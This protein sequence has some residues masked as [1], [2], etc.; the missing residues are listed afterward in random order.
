MEISLYFSYEKKSRMRKLFLVELLNLF[1]L[2]KKSLV[3]RKI[4]K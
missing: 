3:S 4:H 1:D 2:S